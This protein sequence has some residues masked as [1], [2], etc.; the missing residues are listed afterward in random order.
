MTPEGFLGQ[1]KG[2]TATNAIVRGAPAQAYQQ[3]FIHT[4][5]RVQHA[6]P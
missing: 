4:L 2:L 6:L 3:I 5:C 1:L